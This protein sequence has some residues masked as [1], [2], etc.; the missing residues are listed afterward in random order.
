MSAHAPG[1]VREA[2]PCRRGRFLARRFG[3]ASV[4][5]LPFHGDS[6]EDRWAAADSAWALCDGAS[7]GYDGAGWAA[8]LARALV[9]HADPSAAARA[10]RR[11]YRAGFGVYAVQPNPET[12]AAPYPTS[13]WLAEASAARGSFSTALAVRASRSGGFVRAYARG[14]T[15][16]FVRDGLETLAAFPLERADDFGLAPDL[17][18]AGGDGTEDFLVATIPVG[19]TRRPV[20]CLATDALAARILRAAAGER[21]ELWDFLDRAD[22]AQLDAW[23]R[24]EIAAGTL[25]EDDLTL[26]AVRP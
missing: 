11:Q 7:E 12:G 14:D 18:S 20:L 8:A 26:L 16:L 6:G 10:A 5:S 1:P 21:R 22:A 15:A 24:A 19:G 23:A 25:R 3:L 4:L 13:G 17:V 9:L 2:L